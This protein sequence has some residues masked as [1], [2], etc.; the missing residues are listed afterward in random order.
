MTSISAGP[1]PSIS[2]KDYLLLAAL[3]FVF[4]TH[5]P[6]MK[7]ILAE[8]PIFT[9]RWLC[10]V[11]GA[12]GL[13][14]ITRVQGARWRIPREQWP[15]LVLAALLNITGW[16]FFSALAL[17]LSAAGRTAI[18]AYTMPVWAVLLSIPVLGL[19]PGAKEWLGL[20]LGMGA[21]AVLMGDD[22]G[23]LG[24]AP[25]GAL[26]MLGGAI[27]FGFGGVVQKRVPW[28][29]PA[30]VVTA[31]QMAIGAVPLLVAAALLDQF[32]VPAMSQIAFW[33]IVY[34]IVFGVMFGIST[35]LYLV[36]AL[37]IEIASVS[38]LGV[39]VV[40]I[41]SSALLLGEPVG[42]PE[43]AALGLVLAAISR[44]VPMPRLPRRS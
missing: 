19:R 17:T 2:T 41:A 31:W 26:A 8:V 33:G 13:F 4:G 6:I 34:T 35:W 39:P 10:A 18:I 24:E 43:L 14:A 37:P 44:V 1:R 5:W 38:V 22:V 28:Q 32:M 36:R 23:R 9:F 20:A 25:W 11:G 15:V 3:I 16:F 21:M 30:L 27:C 7:V 40:G 29:A 12:L 42:W